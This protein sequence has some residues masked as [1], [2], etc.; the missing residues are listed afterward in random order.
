MLRRMLN[1]EQPNGKHEDK[2]VVNGGRTPFQLKW[3]MLLGMVHQM[4]GNPQDKHED[5]R[6]HGLVA[7]V[8]P[9]TPPSK[10]SPIG[11]CHLSIHFRSPVS[12][13]KNSHPLPV[14]QKDLLIE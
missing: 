14:L 3:R 6:I 1:G 7:G 8:F 4:S 13:K 11:F 9:E 2:N 5:C 12:V 10:P